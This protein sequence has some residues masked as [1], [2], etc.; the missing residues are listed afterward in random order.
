MQIYTVNVTK[1]RI[2]AIVLV[3]AIAIAAIILAIPSR[4]SIATSA[5]LKNIKTESDRLDYIS[6]LGYDVGSGATGEKEVTIPKK[7]DAVY[8]R[9]NQIQQE[10]GFNLEKYAGK[11]IN[12]YSYKVINYQNEPNALLDLLVYKNK[13]IGGAVYSAAP[14][15]FMHE[16]KRIAPKEGA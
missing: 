4:Q 7:F 3:V 5:E 16:L 6:G 9:Y 15:G 8:E 14:D 1:K 10:G 12:L 13:I 11:Q 2:I